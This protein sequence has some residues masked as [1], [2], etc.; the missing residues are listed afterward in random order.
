MF[1]TLMFPLE[2]QLLNTNV[3][4]QNFIVTSQCEV[5]IKFCEVHTLRKGSKHIVYSEES[6]T[7][8]DL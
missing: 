7:A 8:A 5:T 1:D 3:E 6:F 2:A 4:V